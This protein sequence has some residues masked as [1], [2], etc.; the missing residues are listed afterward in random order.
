MGHDGEQQEISTGADVLDR[1]EAYDPGAGWRY[2]F[3]RSNPR[4]DE[5]R[6]HPMADV[7]N[8]AD[9]FA[10]PHWDKAAGVWRVRIGGEPIS[11]PDGRLMHWARFS[12]AY[13]LA[14]ELNRTRRP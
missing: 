6:R 1:V 3:T 9:R 5:E 13:D 14:D 11:G 2:V 10:E 4:A 12:D 7:I 8:E